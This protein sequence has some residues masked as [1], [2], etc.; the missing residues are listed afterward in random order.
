MNEANRGTRAYLKRLPPKE[1]ESYIN[2]FNLPEKHT[3]LL[4]HLYVKKLN[5]IT[6]AVYA[7][8]E[9]DPP[10]YISFFKAVRMHKEALNWMNDQL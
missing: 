6:L 4:Y 7:M 2:S 1:A 5:D 3:R 8:Q 9:D 10:I